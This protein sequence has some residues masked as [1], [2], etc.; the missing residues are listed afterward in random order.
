MGNRG[1]VVARLCRRALLAWEHAVD[2]RGRNGWRAG[3]GSMRHRALFLPSSLSDLEPETPM[4]QLSLFLAL[5][6]L[7]G[8]SSIGPATGVA[9]QVRI[10]P[11]NSSALRVESVQLVAV[12]GRIV[13]SGWVHGRRIGTPPAS[14]L[15]VF[16][17]DAAHREVGRESAP[18]RLRFR[19]HGAPYPDRFAVAFTQ[20]P[21]DAVEVIV[22]PHSGTKHASFPEH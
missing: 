12:D 17:L 13:V 6:T 3:G 19:R 8:C 14:H 11:Q 7:S 18:I 20:W 4:K 2:D 22:A 15:D 10:T 16:V 21:A 1:R 5:I 9:P